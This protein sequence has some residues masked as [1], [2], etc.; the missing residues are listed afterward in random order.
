MNKIGSYI[1]F[2]GLFVC[3]ANVR[4][5]EEFTKNIQKEFKADDNTSLEISNKFGKINIINWDKPLIQINVKITLKHN[6]KAK[7][8]Q[9]LTMINVEFS[10]QGNIIKAI[11]Q[12]NDHFGT[13]R[14]WSESNENKDF[15][16]DYQVSIPKKIALKL[17]NRYGDIFVNEIEGL[18]NVDLKYGN[19][20]M[21]KLSRGDIKPYNNV[22][23]AYGNANIEQCNWLNLNLSYGKI[24]FQTCRT[25]IVIS[26]YSKIN[27]EKANIIA[28]ES[29]YDGYVVKSL[30]NFVITGKY[31]DYKIG[32][33]SNKIDVDSKYSNFQV[34]QVLPTFESININNSY[35]KI[36]LGIDPSASYELSAFVKYASINFPDNGHISHIKQ[37]NQT[38]VSG[39]VGN[40]KTNSKV[41]INSSYGGIN[42]VK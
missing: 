24:N 7:A 33:I 12:I 14:G 26:K 39:M 1:I 28:G 21:N 16:I 25:L 22:S 36:S 20:N 8:E 41:T 6:D 3:I 5:K 11:T 30:N 15:H 31:S 10:E 18:I 19:L 9:L 27:M 37:N 38:T 17:S 29:A 35:G 34:D 13:S 40:Q 23:L 32:Q 4:A 2:V 42:L